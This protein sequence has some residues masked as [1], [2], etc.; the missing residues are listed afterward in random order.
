MNCT[1]D[2]QTVNSLLIAS[3]MCL[4][5]AFFF[6]IMIVAI[7]FSLVG[8]GEKIIPTIVCIFF[9]LFSIWLAQIFRMIASHPSGVPDGSKVPFIYL[10]E[11]S[12]RKGSIESGASLSK[13]NLYLWCIISGIT[14]FSIFYNHGS[15]YWHCS[16][17]TF[18]L[19]F[20]FK[21]S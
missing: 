19:F 4:C 15:L 18:I 5:G 10:M 12:V 21:K 13:Y 7:L 3:R 9:T 2:K 14:G 1:L 17:V 11:A 8:D 16:A 6:V 20:F